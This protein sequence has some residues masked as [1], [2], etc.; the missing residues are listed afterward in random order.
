M[1]EFFLGADT[2]GRDTAVRLLYG[3]RVSLGVGFAATF[4]APS[5]VPHAPRPRSTTDQRSRRVTSSWVA[6]PSRSA[7]TTAAIAAV[8]AFPFAAF[9]MYTRLALGRL[10]SAQRRREEYVGPWL[11]EPVVSAAQFVAA[12]ADRKESGGAAAAAP[13]GPQVEPG[14]GAAARSKTL[15]PPAPRGPAGLR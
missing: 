14:H 2:N 7:E 1:G 4:V 10:R 12:A 13:P 3:G 8:S 5:R 15:A 9:A 11:P 6:A